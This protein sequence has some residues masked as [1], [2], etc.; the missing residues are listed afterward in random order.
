MN[1][2]EMQKAL[3]VLAGDNVEAYGFNY[4]KD[5]TALCALV[6]RLLTKPVDRS[7]WSL[8]VF[9]LLEMGGRDPRM[10]T[11]ADLILAPC[12]IHAEA[13]LRTMKV[14]HADRVPPFVPVKPVTPIRPAD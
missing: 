2:S 9:N 14:W 11:P 7:F 12:E 4:L 3:C 6:D 8:T 10:L 1:Q 5:R 13:L